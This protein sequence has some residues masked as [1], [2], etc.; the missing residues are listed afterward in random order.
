MTSI[1]ERKQKWEDFYE[2]TC[3]T[4]ILIE[5]D[6]GPAPFGSITSGSVG[7]QDTM[8][9]WLLNKYRIQTESMEW[10]DDDR[11]PYVTPIIGAGTWIFAEALGSSVI[12]MDNNTFFVRPAI[13]AVKDFGKLKLPKVEST[14]LMRIFDFAQKLKAAAPAAVLGVPDVQSP[15][16]IAAMV[17]EKADFFTAMYDE[18]QAVKDLI[19]MTNELL[20]EFFD[21]WFKTFGREFI[22]HC[23][24]YYM[25]YGITVSEDE[26][27]SISVDAFREFSY[28]TLCELS[29]RYGR[30]G[31][32]CCAN[33]QH[34]WGVLQSIPGLVVL[35]IV[36]PP[37]IL[38]QA[39]TYF[40]G[41]LGKDPGAVSQMF[42]WD[43]NEYHDYR[44]QAIMGATTHSKTEALEQLKKLRDQAAERE[45]RF[46]TS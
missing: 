23:P 14:S 41:V 34:Q 12:F 25:P 19:C 5:Q 38:R 9:G 33:A 15:L 24:D 35:N 29:K 7:N 3:R 39:S 17:W 16:D 37:D 40:A 21:L 46:R 44:A 45:N 13:T 22:A 11:I 20:T 28:P 10:L 30:I 43:K 32:H 6:C 27:G 26:I 31:I 2:G 18:P 1:E 36:Q 8:F 4:L 42:W